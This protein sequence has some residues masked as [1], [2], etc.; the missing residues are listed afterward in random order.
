MTESLTARHG[1]TPLGRR[2]TANPTMSPR[3]PQ[4]VAEQNV[5]RTKSAQVPIT[6]ARES[7]PPPYSI[8][9]AET[10]FPDLTYSSEPTTLVNIEESSFTGEQVKEQSYSS[11]EPKDPKTRLGSSRTRVISV[12]NYPSLPPVPESQAG[13]QSIPRSSRDRTHHHHRHH[14]QDP[15]LPNTTAPATELRALRRSS[16]KRLSTVENALEL[17]RKYNT[18]LIVDDSNS[19]SG[20]LWLEARDALAALAEV[21]AK[22]DTDGIDVCFLNSPRVGN[23]LTNAHDVKRLFDSI[24]PR[25]FTPLGG[26][27]EELLLIYMDQLETAKASKEPNAMKVVKPVNY[28]VITDGVPSDDPASV[29]VAIAK[30]LD[31]QNFPL[32][33][34][35]IQFVQIGSDSGATAYLTELDDELSKEHG[36]RDIVDTT[37]FAGGRLSAEV[38]I[39]ILLG[40]INRRV[41]KQGGKSVLQS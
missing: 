29:I 26:K 23:N 15:K 36:V 40:G 24:H 17:L 37:P 12:P 22:Y 27:L 41:D 34:L 9:V 20:T 35:G 25:G 6:K 1:S 38:I 11:E 31:A 33:Q 18:V 21:A 2:A 4:S 32:A 5:R 13:L 28:I 39:K 14:S 10:D 3:I 16:T 30:R 7:A 19:M 8:V